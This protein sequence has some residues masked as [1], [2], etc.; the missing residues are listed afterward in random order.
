MFLILF[1]FFYEHYVLCLWV[2]SFWVDCNFWNGSYSLCSMVWLV[3]FTV[4]YRMWWEY[5]KFVHL[6]CRMDILQYRFIMVGI[7]SMTLC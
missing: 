6:N 4:K 5:F 1:C 2:R 3:R 7:F